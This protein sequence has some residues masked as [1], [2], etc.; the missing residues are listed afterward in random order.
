MPDPERRRARHARIWLLDLSIALAA[1]L[2]A[3]VFALGWFAD[4]PCV[5]AGGTV[6][7][8]GGEG[9][10]RFSDGRLEPLSPGFTRTGW[11]LAAV[12][13]LAISGILYW[14]GHRFI[15]GAAHKTPHR[16]T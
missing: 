1:A 12:A 14:S 11:A 5:E 9:F 2:I 6:V 16:G 15:R 8:A 7:H 3:T 13:W 4:R 10:C